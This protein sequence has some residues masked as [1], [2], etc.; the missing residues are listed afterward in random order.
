MSIQTM[1]VARG[2]QAIYEILVRRY[3]QLLFCNDK[4]GRMNVGCHKEPV[5]QNASNM[6]T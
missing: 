3:L 1:P 5:H 4:G 6:F 2:A